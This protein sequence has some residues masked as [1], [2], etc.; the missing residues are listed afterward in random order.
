MIPAK[1]VSVVCSFDEEGSA[2]KRN[3]A[4]PKES[5]VAVMYSCQLYVRLETTFPISITG[6]TLEAFAKT[7]VGKLT[8]FSASY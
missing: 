4:T 3:N 6:I 5:I 2:A 1:V 8:Y 7:C